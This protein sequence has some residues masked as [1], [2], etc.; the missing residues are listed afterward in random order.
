VHE[1]APPVP[2]PT[3]ASHPPLSANVSLS[4]IDVV[5]VRGTMNPDVNEYQF[6]YSIQNNDPTDIPPGMQMNIVA[7]DAGGS[8]VEENWLLQEG[9]AASASTPPRHLTLSLRSGSQ[10]TFTIFATSTL[11]L[12]PLNGSVDLAADGTVT[13]FAFP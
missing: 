6:R 12:T 8:H 9:I 4:G 3:G 13:N 11:S 5:L 2:E 7:T 10:W 1:H